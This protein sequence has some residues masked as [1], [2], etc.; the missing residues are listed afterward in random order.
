LRARTLSSTRTIY[1]GSSSLQKNAASELRAL[2]VPD[3]FLMI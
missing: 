1:R 2:R 3:T